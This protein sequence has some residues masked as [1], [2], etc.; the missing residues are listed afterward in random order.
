LNTYQE[1]LHH[2][3]T[4]IEPPYLADL[5]T[6]IR[7]TKEYNTQVNAYQQRME[8]LA[9]QFKDW[10][11]FFTRLKDEKDY[12]LYLILS[13]LSMECIQLAI[14]TKLIRSHDIP[15]LGPMGDQ[16]LSNP[17]STT[18]R[19]ARLNSDLLQSDGS[20]RLIPFSMMS[21]NVGIAFDTFT[22][23]AKAKGPE[24]GLFFTPH[25]TQI[26][27]FMHM[28]P[29]IMR[30]VPDITQPITQMKIINDYCYGTLSPSQQSP[31]VNFIPFLYRPDSVWGI[32]LEPIQDEFLSATNS[33]QELID[34]S[35][36]DL[37][38]FLRNTQSIDATLDLFSREVES[39]CFILSNMTPKP[40]PIPQ[41]GP[42]AQDYTQISL[43]GKCTLIN[44]PYQPNSDSPKQQFIPFQANSAIIIAPTLPAFPNPIPPTTAAVPGLKWSSASTATTLPL[45]KSPNQPQSQGHV[46]RAGQPIEVQLFTTD[47]AIAVNRYIDR[48]Q[49]NMDGSLADSSLDPFVRT[50]YVNPE[51]LQSIVE[52]FATELGPI[53]I[54]MA[55]NLNNPQKS[56]QPTPYLDL[57]IKPIPKSSDFNLTG[58]FQT[59]KQND[60][61]L[62]IIIKT[63]NTNKD[64]DEES[65]GDIDLFSI[66]DEDDDDTPV[67]YVIY[68][69][70]DDELVQ[71]T[72]KRFELIA[73][74]IQPQNDNPFKIIDK[75]I[76]YYIDMRFNENNPR[77]FAVQVENP[78]GRHKHAFDP[79][80]TRFSTHNDLFSR[81]KLY[82]IGCCSGR[83][84]LPLPQLPSFYSHV[85][86]AIHARSLQS[87]FNL[88]THVIPSDLGFCLECFSIQ[89]RTAALRST[90][91]HRGKLCYSF[92]Q[93]ARI[94]PTEEPMVASRID[95][96]QDNYSSSSKTQTTTTY[97]VLSLPFP[98]LLYYFITAIK[99]GGWATGS[100]KD[101][102]GD[103]LFDQL[104]EI[105]YS[106]D[107]LIS[108]SANVV[109]TCPFQGHRSQFNNQSEEVHPQTLL[110][111][112]ALRSSAQ[113]HYKCC[114]KLADS[115]Q[116]HFGSN[117]SCPMIYCTVCDLFHS[118][119]KTCNWTCC[120]VAPGQR[121]HTFDLHQD[122]LLLSDVVQRK[123]ST[124]C[125]HRGCDMIFCSS[126]RCKRWHT[127]S[128][129]TCDITKCPCPGAKEFSKV[130]LNVQSSQGN[131]ILCPSCRT[132]A[133]CTICTSWHTDQNPCIDITTFKSCPRCKTPTELRDGCSH[134][135]CMCGSHWCFKCPSG[136]SPDFSS[137]SACYAHLSTNHQGYW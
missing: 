126:P 74:K 137:G 124:P 127:K 58:A 46:P 100:L 64:N 103:I 72:F 105:R 47:V 2:W 106:T 121:N 78:N 83:E 115:N 1:E 75:M 52:D 6:H 87:P 76:D 110:D 39:G 7:L 55:S 22:R 90:V 80:W 93:N 94:D 117:S 68:S 81:A 14:N 66:D 82:C 98:T 38:N 8:A 91:N 123:T 29:H 28:A 49:A 113:N 33:A 130:A 133:Y 57:S 32:R 89:S 109:V 23:L 95:I 9:A 104:C 86:H 50:K 10:L 61:A 71:S 5:D 92:D 85:I 59:H 135:T 136:K 122:R 101:R 20:T 44:A 42:L 118:T 13:M 79:M 125:P 102:I 31:K 51:A 128:D 131:N 97:R 111:V 34:N 129:P 54:R 40:V 27:L 99:E 107:H 96:F 21:I 26:N 18:S 70:E 36:S 19:I 4:V 116:W 132:N 60:P 62:S 69:S 53:L 119:K 56:N 134:I 35:D 17:I 112:A 120:Q 65:D 30:S 3:T 11:T 45:Y 37:R 41:Y 43:P 114:D 108:T 12:G 15:P 48:L 73:T 77:S 88:I 24:I 84:H 67:S 16:N 63:F 25:Y